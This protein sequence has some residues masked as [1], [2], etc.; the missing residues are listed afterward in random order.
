MSTESW[1]AGRVAV[2]TGAGN[3]LGREHALFLARHG[4]KVVVN[5][6]GGT[7]NGVGSTSAAA[8]QVV[9]EIRQ[10]GGEA[11]ANHDSVASFDGA[12]RIIDTAVRAFGRVDALV[13]NAGILRD[14][15][16]AKMELDDFEQVLRVH[17]L[18]SVYCTKAAWPL[19]MEQGYGRIVLTTSMSGT[20]GN[21]GQSNYGAAKMGVLGLM[22][23]LAIEGAK[24]KIL[25]NAVS[26]G[27]A[28]RM[29]SGLSTVS[30]ELLRTMSPAHV[31]PA[32][33]WLASERCSITGETMF[34]A[35]GGFGRVHMFETPGIQFDPRHEITLEMLDDAMPR[36]RDLSTSIP[37]EPGPQGFIGRRL[38][39]IGLNL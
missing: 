22:N 30:D 5:D 6:M 9:T 16:F 39:T 33:A 26:P 23:C 10:R 28:T 14:K 7:V 13:N 25:V 17:L 37:T 20:N 21:F 1:M 19:M 8:D 24:S 36:I 31:S 27:A 3:G 11:V 12:K 38:A 18:G 35:A 2:V 29:T 4:A 32:V 34:A 15:S